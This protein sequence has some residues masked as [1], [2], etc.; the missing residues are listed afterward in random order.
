MSWEDDKR[1]SDKFLH[2]M[3]GLIGQALI[4]AAPDVEDRERNTDLIV[5]K[6]D[7]V[8]IACRVRR[9]KYLPY[10]SQFTLRAGRPSGNETELSK[11]ITGWGNYLFY[12]F[13]NEQETAIEQWFLGDLSRFRIWHSRKLAYNKGNPPG[14]KKAN[15][16]SSSWFYAFE[17]RQIPG[18]I[19]ASS[20][21]ADHL[22]D[23][24]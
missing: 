6:L 19:V 4:C 17:S 11:V 10:S 9:H 24:A 3:K 7:S 2:Q 21:S 12:G 20:L 22:R 14:I 18:F 8:R 23:A 15:G 16:D 13:A 5:L 1:W